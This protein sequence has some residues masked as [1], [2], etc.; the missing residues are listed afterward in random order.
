MSSYFDN[1]SRA[2]YEAAQNESD[3]SFLESVVQIEAGLYRDVTQ[4]TGD[5]E[6]PDDLRERILGVLATKGGDR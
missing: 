5:R 4:L 6:F 1:L 3:E 2:V